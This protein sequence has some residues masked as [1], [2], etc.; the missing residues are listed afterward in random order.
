MHTASNSWLKLTPAMWGWIVPAGT[1]FAVDAHS[2]IRSLNAVA[3][4]A[5]VLNVFA[6]SVGRARAALYA[7][8]RRNFWW[9]A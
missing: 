6:Q 4:I 1:S 8:M 9:A 5:G 7:S 2:N 3:F